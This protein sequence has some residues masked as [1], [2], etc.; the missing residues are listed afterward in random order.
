MAYGN[1]GTG[2]GISQPRDGGNPAGFSGGFRSPS[3]TRGRDGNS[4]GSFAG[5]FNPLDPTQAPKSIFQQAG[6]LQS[7]A[8]TGA[9]GAEVD[10]LMQALAQIQQMMDGSSGA[11]FGERLNS[12]IGGDQFA[13]L[14][15]ERQRGM[16]GQLSAGGLTRSGTALEAAGAIPMEL[17]FDLENQQFGRESG[18]STQ[19]ANLLAS[20]G[21]AKAGGIRGSAEAEAGGIL[22]EK[23]YQFAG[24]QQRQQNNNDMFSAIGGLVGGPAGAF[25]GSAFSDPRLKTNVKSIGKIGPL[26]LVTWDWVDAAKDT[27]VSKFKTMGFMS[28][29]IKEHYPDLVGSHGGYDVVNYAGVMERLNGDS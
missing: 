15:D 20:I 6:D 3:P 29:Q 1:N 14:V 27:V 17:A 7:T 2:G 23:A 9:A 18:F 11:G 12:I 4:N 25:L 22:G 24:D 16:Q 8:A 10:G 5:G 21:G 19:I 26:D 28:T 13:G